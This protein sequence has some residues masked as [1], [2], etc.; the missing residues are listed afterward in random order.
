M[1]C[2]LIFEFIEYLNFIL[3]NI[4]Q[5]FGQMSIIEG[6][7]L[8]EINHPEANMLIKDALLTSKNPILSELAKNS[9]PFPQG[10]WDDVEKRLRKGKRVFY[11]RFMKSKYLLDFIVLGNRDYR[12]FM[13]T[14]DVGIKL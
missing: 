13:E 1:Q 14:M 4:L 11:V 6:M 8:S 3:I 7:R 5:S 9:D 10:G 12:N 2:V